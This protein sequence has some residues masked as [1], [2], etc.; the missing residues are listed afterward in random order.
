MLW[1]GVQC[2]IV[3]FPGHNQFFITSG[4]GYSLLKKIII[5]VESVTLSPYDITFCHY[6][7][8]TDSNTVR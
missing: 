2:V 7:Y 5:S 4:T 3:L 8:Y 6:I 1:V